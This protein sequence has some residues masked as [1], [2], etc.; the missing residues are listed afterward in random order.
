MKQMNKEHK[1]YKFGDL[2]YYR[3]IKYLGIVVNV[4]EYNNIKFYDILWC[5]S[6]NI[7]TEFYSDE[8]YHA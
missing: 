6:A 3:G 7:E 4:I 2:I 5:D 1:E 8:L